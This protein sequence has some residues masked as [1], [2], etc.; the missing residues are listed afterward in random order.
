[1]QLCAG[2]RVQPMPRLLIN[3]LLSLTTNEHNTR[4][5]FALN[6]HYRHTMFFFNSWKIKRYQL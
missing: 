5:W 3:F 4:H 1:M 2:V 6:K